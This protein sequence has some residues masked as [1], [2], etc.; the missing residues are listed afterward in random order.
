MIS[1]SSYSGSPLMIIGGGG[2]FLW[3]KTYCRNKVQEEICGMYCGFSSKVEDRAYKH[4]LL[5]LPR[6]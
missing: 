6:F 5:S 4:F 1:L 2:C 3:T